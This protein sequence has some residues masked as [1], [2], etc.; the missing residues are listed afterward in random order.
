MCG[1]WGRGK[2][3][4]SQREALRMAGSNSQKSQCRLRTEQIAWRSWAR[5]WLTWQSRD[6]M[7]KRRNSW[8]FADV[9]GG[10]NGFSCNWAEWGSSQYNLENIC[11][12]VRHVHRGKSEPSAS[13]RLLA[14]QKT[15]RK[16]LQH[17][18]GLCQHPLRL[19]TWGFVSAEDLTLRL[20]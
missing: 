7:K 19:G 1:D 12:L 3:G 16:H 6:I 18:V 14:G 8:G 13:H 11:D 17:W 10:K 15:S 5:W 9:L 2:G 20:P 4:S